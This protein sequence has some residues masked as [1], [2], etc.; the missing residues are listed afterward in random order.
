MKALLVG[1]TPFSVTIIFGV[2]KLHNIRCLNPFFKMSVVTVGS[3]MISTHLENLSKKTSSILFP[4]LEQG[5]G[6]TK[7]AQT[8]AHGSPG[9]CVSILPL[10]FCEFHLS[11]WHDSKAHIIKSLL[12]HIGMHSFHAWD[13]SVTNLFCICR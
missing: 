6:P 11:L 1:C 8:I 5:N 10:G 13:S 4:C 3:G 9:N 7:S 12:S 2:R